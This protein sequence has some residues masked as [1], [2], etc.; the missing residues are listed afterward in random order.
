[1]LDYIEGNAKAM[2][3]WVQTG[4]LSMIN[5]RNGH[6]GNNQS[7]LSGL[8]QDFYTEPES[9]FSYINRVQ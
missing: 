6:F 3:Y 7:F 2:G 5:T 9:V 1:M 4:A 8:Y